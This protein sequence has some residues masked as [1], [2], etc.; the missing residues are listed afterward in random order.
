M[1]PLVFGENKQVQFE[2]EAA[3]FAAL[4]FLAKDDG[5]T[6]VVWADHI[7]RIDCFIPKQQFPKCFKDCTFDNAIHCSEFVAY[8]IANHKFVANENQNINNII[9]TVPYQYADGFQ[10][11]YDL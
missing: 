9:I 6:K 1:R 2:N 7:G 11:A 5:S 10:A 4:G 8:L 3:F